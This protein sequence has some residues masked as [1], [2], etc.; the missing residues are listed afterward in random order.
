MKNPQAWV[1]SLMLP[2]CLQVRRPDRQYLFYNIQI[3]ILFYT[4]GNLIDPTCEPLSEMKRDGDTRL[5][6]V[7]RGFD[8]MNLSIGLEEALSS[9]RP[10]RDGHDLGWAPLT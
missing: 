4:W 9:L 5:H 6:H 7:M 2:C 3:C 8:P 1:V 10:P